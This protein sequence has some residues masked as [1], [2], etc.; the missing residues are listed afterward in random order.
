M[1]VLVIECKQNSQKGE[2]LPGLDLLTEPTSISLQE[3]SLRT[4]NSPQAAGTE[5][6][7]KTV[8]DRSDQD[9]QGTVPVTMF[10]FQSQALGP[11]PDTSQRTPIGWWNHPIVLV[12][13]LCY[14]AA[15]NFVLRKVTD[16]LCRRLVL[17]E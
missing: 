4:L 11:V 10:M 1:T 12:L 13:L 16:R 14:Y 8:P 6:R 2:E 3:L 7:S 5:L 17:G 9:N 15:Q